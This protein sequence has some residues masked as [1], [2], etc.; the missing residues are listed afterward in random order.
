ME[1]IRNLVKNKLLFK[2]LEFINFII[3][4]LNREEKKIDVAILRDL[5]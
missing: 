4:I 3:L 1:S 2:I 5:I